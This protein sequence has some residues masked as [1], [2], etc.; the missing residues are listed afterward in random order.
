MI[1]KGLKT[2]ICIICLSNHYH[3]KDQIETPISQKEGEREKI[4]LII[5]R[6][7]DFPPTRI[8]IA[9]IKTFR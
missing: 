5:L 1:N 2:C 4:F 8:I 3:F 9:L 7:N 6:W